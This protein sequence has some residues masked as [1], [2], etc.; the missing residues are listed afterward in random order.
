[1][2]LSLLRIYQL[3]S[4]QCCVMTALT[5]ITLNIR[6]C[7]SKLALLKNSCLRKDLYLCKGVVGN[8]DAAAC[9]ESTEVVPAQ[10]ELWSVGENP[11]GDSKLIRGM[12][13]LS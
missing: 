8:T 1:M 12:K 2:G 6:D 11:E 5:L 10:E 9:L 7:E 13:H 3:C 4:V